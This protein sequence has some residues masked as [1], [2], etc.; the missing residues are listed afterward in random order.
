MEGVNSVL[1]NTL[2]FHLW[3]LRFKPWAPSYVRKFQVSY[4]WLSVYSVEYWP[5]RRF[6]LK[7]THRDT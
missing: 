6:T 7:I 5:A 1:D 2:T 4:Q 3:G